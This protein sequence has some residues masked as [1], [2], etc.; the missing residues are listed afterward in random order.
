MDSKKSN[1]ITE[2]VR[3]QQILKKWKNLATK[4]T[5]TTSSSK[6][7]KFLKKTLSFSESSKSSSS[8]AANNDV[9]PKGYLA[10]LCV[11][12]E[13]KRF[14]IPTDYL[15]HRAFRILLKEA[16]EVFG[17]QQEGILKIPCQVPV[18]ENIL[19]MMAEPDKRD[20]PADV[21]RLHDFET[22]D[23]TLDNTTSNIAADSKLKPST[24]AH[25]H[26]P[27]QMCI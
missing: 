24:R 2:I 20:T 21:F 23:I 3:L 11:G 12:E 17:F 19:K 26:H 27:P 10:V 9:V 4:N 15:G 18:F 25:H 13:L 8:T 14:V 7:N 5:T 6:S 1:K 16:E 22:D